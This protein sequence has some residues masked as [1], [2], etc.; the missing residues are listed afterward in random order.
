MEIKQCTC[1]NLCC[2]KIKNLSV[3]LDT[4]KILQDINMHFHCGEITAVIGP[5]GGGKSTLLKAIIGEYQH[6]GQLLF[7]DSNNRLTNPKIGYV[8]QK[9]SIDADSPITVLDLFLAATTRRPVCFMKSKS[10]VSYSKA[11]LAMLDCQHLINRKLAELSGGELQRV[12]LALALMP[13]PNLL[14]LDEPISGVDQKGNEQF[15]YMISKLRQE[16]DLAIIIVTH[17]FIQ[18]KQFANR[19]YL[20]NRKVLASGTWQEVFQHTAF[21]EIFGTGGILC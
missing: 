5:N 1:S 10:A 8:P 20:I 6:E 11:V 7:I 12:T 4:D 15:W 3:T 9:L 18:V 2:T 19:V 17:D 16:H 13:M 14:L 21:K